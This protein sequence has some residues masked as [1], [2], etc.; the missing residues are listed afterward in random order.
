[1]PTC[2][3][4]NGFFFLN[5]VIYVC[6]CMWVCAP[7]CMCLRKTEKGVR[8]PGAG[9]TERCEPSDVGAGIK[10]SS[11]GVVQAAEPFSSPRTL[12]LN[13]YFHILKTC[14]QLQKQFKST[15]ASKYNF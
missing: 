14:S 4:L 6:V 3:F 10:L 9:I 1:M 15:S 2:L 7:E 13:V 12:I 8:S 11:A 5:Y